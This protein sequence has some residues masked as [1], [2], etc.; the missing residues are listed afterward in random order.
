[1][2]Q[3]APTAGQLTA[4]DALRLEIERFLYKEA[5]LLD[6]RRFDEWLALFAEDATYIV[7]NDGD[8]LN[9]SEVGALIFDDYRAISAR[10]RRFQ[11]PAALTQI[12]APKTRHFIS[13]VLVDPGGDNDVGVT[14]Y[15]VVYVSRRGR[16]TTYPGSAEYLLRRVG[17]DWL[18]RRKKVCLIN[19][20]RALSSLP[21]L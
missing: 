2:T 16:D 6:Q 21:I 19:S 17:D 3:A 12:P 13:N 10:V 14:S 20:D 8:D 15:Q 9:P 4:L 1:M 11:H 7:P 18:I 5:S